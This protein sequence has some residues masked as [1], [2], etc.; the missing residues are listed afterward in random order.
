MIAHLAGEVI[1]WGEHR[2][3]VDVHGVGY[4]VLAPLSTT[5]RLRQGEPARLHIH[6]LVREDA[7]HLYGFLTRAERDMFL[8]LIGVSQVGPKVALAALSTLPLADLA[9]AIQREDITLISKIPGVG[10]KT[11]SRLALELKDKAVAITGPASAGRMVAGAAPPTTAPAD[12]LSAL[13][14]LGYSKA[15]AESAIQAVVTA[16]ATVEELIR[17][18]LVALSQSG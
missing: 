3:V 4:E 7:I 9:G 14:N 2:L 15:R 16:D 5:A 13:V 1:S 12:A 17:K 8:L 11:A 6:M 10:K 18:A